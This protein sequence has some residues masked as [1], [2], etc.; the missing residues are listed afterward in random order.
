MKTT[1]ATMSALALIS[2]LAACSKQEEASGDVV[3]LEND[4]N[5][6]MADPNN[7]G[8]CLLS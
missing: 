4:M 6:M 3:T 8:L 2:T 7:I 1:L 5:T